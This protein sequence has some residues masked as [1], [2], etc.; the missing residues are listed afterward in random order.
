MSM[1]IGKRASMG[2]KPISC[3]I[4]ALEYYLFAFYSSVDIWKLILCGVKGDSIY[5][6]FVFFA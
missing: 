3:M 2:L 1:G 6:K 5:S 4:R